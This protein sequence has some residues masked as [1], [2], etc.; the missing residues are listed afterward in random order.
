MMCS[1]CQKTL[2]LGVRWIITAHQMGCLYPNNDA[3]FDAVS[4][5]RYIVMSTI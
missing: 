2:K 4:L 1:Q 3:K 5:I